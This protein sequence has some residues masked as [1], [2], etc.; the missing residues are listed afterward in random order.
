ML[1]VCSFP[2][3]TLKIKVIYDEVYSDLY[4]D[5]GSQEY[6]AMNS[7]LINSVS[8]SVISGVFL[9]QANITSNSTPKEPFQLTIRCYV[10]LI[11]CHQM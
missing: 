4:T 3:S 11:L 7:T 6:Q 5:E 8:I 2:G 10:F 1:N 9:P